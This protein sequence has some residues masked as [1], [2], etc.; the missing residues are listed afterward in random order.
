LIQT[1]SVAVPFGVAI[2]VMLP[3]SSP[4]RSAVCGLT[5]TQ[6]IH[7]VLLTGSGSSCSHGRFA[8]RPS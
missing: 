3:V 7:D 1:G 4:S 6:E 8:V 5:S 2:S